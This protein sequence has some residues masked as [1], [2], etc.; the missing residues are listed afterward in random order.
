MIRFLADALRFYFEFHARY[1][2]FYGAFIHDPLVVAAALDPGLVRTE[3]VAVE[4]A[5]SGGAGDGQ[6]MGD[7]RRITGRVPNADVA[8]DV[9]VDAFRE[10]LLE[11]VGALALARAG[12]LAEDRA[13]LARDLE[14]LARGDHEH[15]HP[16]TALRD[17][18]VRLAVLVERRIHRDPEERRAPPR[19]SP[20]SAPSA[21]R[22]RP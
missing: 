3:P 17:L 15:P 2:G 22:C 16:G 9:D 13:H 4:V 20:G 1:D 19:P 12:R 8:V 18:A 7:W 10:R 14:I 6:T 11:R 5:A 21:R